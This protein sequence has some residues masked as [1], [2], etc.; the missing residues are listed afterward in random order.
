MTTVST[1]SPTFICMDI[2][3]CNMWS[4]KYFDN[5]SR[6]RLTWQNTLMSWVNLQW[7]L[8]VS[9]L[10]VMWYLGLEFCVIFFMI[11]WIIF[12]SSYLLSDVHQICLPKTEWIKICQGHKKSKQHYVRVRTL[13]QYI[14]YFMCSEKR[15]CGT[16]F[17]FFDI[18]R[19]Q[20]VVSGSLPFET[21]PVK[22]GKKIKINMGSNNPAIS[23]WGLIS[24]T[25][26]KI[27]HVF[28]IKTIF[29]IIKT[30]LGK[31]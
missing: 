30:Q 10:D 19:I 21:E 26:V 27:K 7:Q 18:N 5:C 12:W 13:W 28:V 22:M 15:K 24:Y 31:S 8:L 14:I 3:W 20:A 9:S 4:M 2:K 23:L 16:A 17:N 29:L 1:M 6:M 11:Y 25:E